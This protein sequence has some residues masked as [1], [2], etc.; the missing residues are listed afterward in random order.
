[1][2][3]LCP[4]ASSE[5]ACVVTIDENAAS[6]AT[7]TVVVSEAPPVATPDATT[8]VTG[9]LSYETVAPFDGEVGRPDAT[10]TLGVLGELHAVHKS[11]QPDCETGN[12]NDLS[13][14]RRHYLN[15]RR[16]ILRPSRQLGHT[17]GISCVA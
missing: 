17:R 9:W 13:G 8:T 6:V 1:M 7:S 12:C 10:L 3:V 11:Q 2:I 16:W 15:P 14:S 4:F 5:T